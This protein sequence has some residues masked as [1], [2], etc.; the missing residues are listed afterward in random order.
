MEDW[1]EKVEAAHHM[2]AALCQPRGSKGAREWTMS[3]PARRDYDP[4]LVITAG[5]CSAERRIATLDAT[6]ARLREVVPEDIKR[7]GY[8]IGDVLRVHA[9][10]YP[11]EQADD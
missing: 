5:L 10:L 2:V 11:K 6:I 8:S 1:K 9:I 7:T 3:I 4:D